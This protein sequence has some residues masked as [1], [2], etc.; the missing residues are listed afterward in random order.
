MP[1]IDAETILQ[2]RIEAALR[3]LGVLE[4]SIAR[5]ALHK[6]LGPRFANLI[7]SLREDIEALQKTAKEDPDAHDD[8]W[9]DLRRLVA[10]SE[11][12]AEEYLRCLQG[13]TIRKADGG[14][15]EI[16]D[17]LIH[18]LSLEADIQWPRLTILS[19]GEFLSG[20]T[21]VIGARFPSFDVWNLPVAVHEFGHFLFE[22]LTKPRTKELLFDEMVRDERKRIKKKLEKL[23]DSATLESSL[24]TAAHH[25]HEFFADLFA[26]FTVGPA[27][28]YTCVLLRFDPHT[29]TRE[30][31]HHPS[32]AARVAAM[33][34]G[35]E[36]MDPGNFLAVANTLRE[37]WSG[38]VKRAGLDEPSPEAVS[39]VEETADAVLKVLRRNLS[40]K[41]RYQSWPRACQLGEELMKK[42]VDEIVASGVI[43]EDVL[44]AA[45][46]ARLERDPVRANGINSRAM[47]VCR[48][49]AETK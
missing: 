49:I 7:Q 27:Y 11:R 21:D 46:R 25:L 26:V 48:K 44:N 37:R 39:A 43:I 4:E 23:V 17:F 41:V 36:E 6:K 42:P 9:G 45:W 5:T 29:A 20:M 16:S 28:A 30:T 18:R 1:G 10:D 24:Q 14:Y 40:K 22:R 8:C 32:N 19:S 12:V 35:L 33:T 31:A 2:M 15:L 47:A 13:S 3:D 34:R 38:S